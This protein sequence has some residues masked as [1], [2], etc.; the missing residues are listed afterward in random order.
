MALDKK[1]LLHQTRKI[2]DGMKSDSEKRR[3]VVLGEVEDVKSSI[4]ALNAQ[5]EALRNLKATE[6]ERLENVKAQRAG[7]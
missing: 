6:M 7:D 5:V 2:I 3:E 1:R 4:A